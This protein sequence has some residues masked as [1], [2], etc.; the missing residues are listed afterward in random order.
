[1]ERERKTKIELYHDNF[2][3]YKPYLDYNYIN[4]LKQAEEK[5]QMALDLFGGSGSTLI[6][7]E[8]EK[9]D[10]KYIQERR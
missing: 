9:R 3:N 8:Q 2:Q 1:M 6:A 10:G 4:E 5:V 7:C